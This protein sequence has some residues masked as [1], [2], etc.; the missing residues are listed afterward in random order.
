MKTK[1]NTET[2][3][4]ETIKKLVADMGTNEVARMVMNA[5]RCS[6]EKAAKITRGQTDTVSYSDALALANEFRISIDL[7]IHTDGPDNAA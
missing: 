2:L 7:L 3:R 1:A 5:L 4:G 6:P